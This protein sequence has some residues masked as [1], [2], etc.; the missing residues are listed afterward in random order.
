MFVAIDTFWNFINSI[1]FKVNGNVVLTIFILLIFF[2]FYKFWK[3][4]KRNTEKV[5]SDLLNANELIKFNNDHRA[6]FYQEFENIDEK[7][8]NNES[9]SHSW[10][11]F[12]EHIIYPSDEEA[13]N[14]SLDELEIKNSI[15]P[16]FFFNDESFIEDNIDLRYL[17]SIPGKLTAFGILGTFVGLTIG[18]ASATFSMSS[19][20]GNQAGGLDTS[21]LIYTLV[22]LLKGASLAF[23]TSV[24]GILLSIIFSFVEKK[25]ITQIRKELSDFVEN[26]EKC[27]KLIT[28]EQVALEINA[29]IIEQN[30]KFDG[31]SNELTIALENA[32]KN[33]FET[34]L[35]TGI[36]EI[37]GGLSSIKEV[38]QGFSDNLMTELVDKLSGGLSSEAKLNQQKANQAFE[39][40]QETFAKQA[41]EMVASQNTMASTSRQLL[42]EISQTSKSNQEA[43]NEQLNSTIGGLK[44]ALDEIN[45][46]FRQN[47]SQSSENIR[48]TLS[49]TFSNVSNNM[50]QQQESMNQKMESSSNNLNNLI[51]TIS[52]IVSETSRLMEISNENIG[53]NNSLSENYKGLLTEQQKVVTLLDSCSSK[54]SNSG[55]LL[56][57]ASERIGVASSN[58]ESTSKQLKDSNSSLETIWKNYEERFENV[59]TNLSG[60]FNTF[61]QGSNQF[62]TT[63]NEYVSG[64][65][66]EYERAIN[67]LGGQLEELADAL[68]DNKKNS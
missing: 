15:Q 41:Q 47:I 65:T 11:E 67:I 48:E 39:N 34:P 30:K 52:Q 45:T 53:H 59:D 14:K 22:Q 9:F 2:A 8:T 35:K 5:Y 38:Q 1:L 57:S 36:T 26:L 43:L 33:A 19:F 66:K 55:Q 40:L 6:K 61:V 63:V 49:E 54:I 42:N 44:S 51:E 18:I 62:H 31:F 4:F 17:D 28:N 20:S 68:G 21:K 56:D 50:I 27:V 13:S 60:A 23:V 24:L 12:K 25:K 7:L 29:N 16:A 46:S 32:L 10:Q 3:T 64:L 58:L 37:V